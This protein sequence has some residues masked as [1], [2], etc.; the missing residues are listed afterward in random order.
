MSLF[1]EFTLEDEAGRPKNIDNSFASKIKVSYHVWFINSFIIRVSH[2]DKEKLASV[3]CDLDFVAIHWETTAGTASWLHTCGLHVQ[4]LSKSKVDLKQT[5]LPFF[6]LCRWR[7]AQ[8]RKL[9][10]LL[11]DT[12]CYLGFLYSVSGKLV[13]KSTTWD[14]V[15]GTPTWH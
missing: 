11:F 15:N 6:T 14:G 9:G 10:F 2:Y 3:L 7:W 12:H 4:I 13:T 5:L 8:K 1:S